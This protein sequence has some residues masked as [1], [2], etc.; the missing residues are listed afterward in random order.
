MMV[1]GHLHRFPSTIPTSLH[2]IFIATMSTV[3]DGLDVSCC[4]RYLHNVFFFCTLVYFL[5]ESYWDNVF[6]T[7]VIAV[8]Q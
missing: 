7:Y 8:H 3:L 4:P 5:F 2:E 1:T 6:K